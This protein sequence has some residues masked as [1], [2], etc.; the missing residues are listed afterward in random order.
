MPH[1]GGNTAGLLAQQYVWPIGDT[2]KQRFS[3]AK[4]KA[5]A[6]TRQINAA[7]ACAEP[8]QLAPASISYH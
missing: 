8:T 1:Q 4:L 5:I 7:V 3:C 2:I 6:I